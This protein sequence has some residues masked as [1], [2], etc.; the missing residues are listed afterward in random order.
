MRV[1]FY[2]DSYCDLIWFKDQK[3][4]EDPLSF[5]ERKYKP[6]PG[7]VLDDYKSQVLS[8]G[9]GGSSLF[10]AIQQWNTDIEKFNGCIYDVV[11]I[12]L[13]WWERLYTPNE[14]YQPV[15]LARAERRPMPASE[16]PTINFDEVNQGIDL[17]YK[18]L[19][20]SNQQLFYYELMVKWILD[21]PNQYPDTKFI[22]LPCTEISR[23]LALKHFST[24]VLANF[25]FET[26][27][28]LENGSPGPMPIMC[29][30]TGHL[31]DKNHES[32][33]SE[34]KKIVAAYDS[35]KNTI[36]DLDYSN[37]DLSEIPNFKD[38]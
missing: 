1:G 37:F 14:S 29:G 22:F 19:C 27:S 10:H 11:F 31:N 28:N 24:G 12:S 32:F 7:R 36:V 25:S 34:M 3:Y 4:L 38:C 9:L 23:K 35:I 6:W 21:L 18:Y 16:D 5:I 20:F 17:Y 8:S 13:T 26:L 2:G 33:A 30:R 15:F